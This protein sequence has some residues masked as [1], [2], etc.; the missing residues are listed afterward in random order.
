[1]CD[2]SKT[3]F[4]DYLKQNLK[5]DFSLMRDLFS[6]GQVSPEP[7][8]YDLH[9]QTFFPCRSSNG[10]DLGEVGLSFRGGEK[11]GVQGIFMDTIVRCPRMQIGESL[12]GW[13]NPEMIVQWAEEAH[14][15]VHRWFFAL[16]KGDL[17]KQ[18]T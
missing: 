2:F 11:K 13:K 3:N 12:P 14:K 7:S 18:F 1:V 16:I 6:D 4:L 9:L 5:I 17:E 10:E 15:I 8:P